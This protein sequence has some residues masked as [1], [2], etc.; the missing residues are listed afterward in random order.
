MPTKHGRLIVVGIGLQPGR[1]AG[2]RAISEIRRADTVFVLADPF[3]IDWALGLNPDTRNLGAFYAADRDRRESYAGMQHTMLKQVRAGRHVC[4]VFYGHPGVFAQVGRKTM[5]QARAEGFEVRMEPGIS[6]EACLYADLDLDPGEH[7][8][9]SIEATQLLIEQRVI[10]PASL[11]LL[12]QVMH[13]GNL[14]CTGFDAHPEWLELLVEKLV[15]WYPA[16]TGV[17]LYE[18]ATLPIQDFRAERLTLGELPKARLTE[19][20]TLVIPP[21]ATP[22]KDV[23]MLAR[24]RAMV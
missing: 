16:E 13:T 22:A 3:A 9:Q 17:I 14:A 7:G 11:L 24:L 12:W 18:A 5:S 6:A 1:H 2:A 23:E 10:D 15:R 19:V 8:V 21:V 4:A 20:T